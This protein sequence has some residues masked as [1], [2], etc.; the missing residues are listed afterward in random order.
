VGTDYIKTVRSESDGKPRRGTIGG[1]RID[2]R[3]ERILGLVDICLV[4]VRTA[5]AFDTGI[6][7]IFDGVGDFRTASP[8]E[9]IR[10]CLLPAQYYGPTN[11]N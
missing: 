3:N 5:E 9:D 1:I 10:S 8:R 6:F 7:P 11:Y 2:Q 4:K